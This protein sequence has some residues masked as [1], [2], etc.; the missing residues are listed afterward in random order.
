MPLFKI[1]ETY[2][3]KEKKNN[4]VYVMKFLNKSSMQLDIIFLD[5]YGFIHVYNNYM[6]IKFK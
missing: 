4:N 6:S 5:S 2:L 3:E 1:V